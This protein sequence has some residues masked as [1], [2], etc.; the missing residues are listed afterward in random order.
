MQAEVKIFWEITRKKSQNLFWDGRIWLCRDD[1][2]LDIGA[3]MLP[4]VFFFFIG[5]ILNKFPQ[6]KW[7]YRKL[8]SVYAQKQQKKRAF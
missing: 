4:C 1:G 5:Y 6:G 2:K 3:A 7:A 8:N